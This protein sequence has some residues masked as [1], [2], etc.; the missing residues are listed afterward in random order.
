M[1]SEQMVAYSAGK[2][3][4]VIEDCLGCERIVDKSGNQY[5][6][7]YISPQAKWRLGICNFATHKKPEI[8]QVKIHINPLKAAKR[9][10]RAK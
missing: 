7:A 3:Q 8:E 10:S 1:Q 9:A 6:Q 5:C 4:S 2:F